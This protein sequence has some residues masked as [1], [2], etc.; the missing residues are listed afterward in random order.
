MHRAGVLGR[1]GWAAAIADLHSG[2]PLVPSA[3]NW[4][5]AAAYPSGEWPKTLICPARGITVL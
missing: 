1:A 4:P 2:L 5:R 3:F